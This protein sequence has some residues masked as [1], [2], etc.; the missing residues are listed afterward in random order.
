MRHLCWSQEQGIGEKQ[1]GRQRER[2]GQNKD[3]DYGGRCI[4]ELTTPTRFSDRDRVRVLSTR[5]QEN[6]S[7]L[8]HRQDVLSS[9]RILLVSVL[10][11]FRCPPCAK[12]Q[13]RPRWSGGGQS[14][15]A[16]HPMVHFSVDRLADFGVNWL[17]RRHLR[18][19]VNGRKE[20]EGERQM[21]M[22]QK[23]ERIGQRRE[24]HRWVLHLHGKESM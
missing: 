23:G 9:H 4:R 20:G 6:A 19:K 18:L 16:G 7:V 21:V 17:R 5:A 3:K 1:T 2:G 12:T 14:A 13:S 15:L 22:M 11:Q 24:V 10:L 8:T